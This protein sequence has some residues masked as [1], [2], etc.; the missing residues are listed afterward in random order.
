MDESVDRPGEHAV[1]LSADGWSVR[2]VSPVQEYLLVRRT[3][4]AEDWTVVTLMK[5]PPHT[6]QTGGDLVT[7]QHAGRH[8]QVV[9][10]G[11]DL[12]V[13]VGHRVARQE[14]AGQAGEEI[15]QLGQGDLQGS[16][17]SR[18]GLETENWLL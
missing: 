8:P 10:L 16:A 12:A 3:G 9:Q 18:H 14:G 13:Q 2:P 5:V 15:V 17:V 7:L 4:L 11:Q 1:I 6:A